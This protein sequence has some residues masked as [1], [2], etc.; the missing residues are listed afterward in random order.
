M[1]IDKRLWHEHCVSEVIEPLSSCLD[2]CSCDLMFSE[3]CFYLT[4][5]IEEQFIALIDDKPLDAK[6]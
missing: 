5:T 4:K 2:S 1:R 6:N 3:S